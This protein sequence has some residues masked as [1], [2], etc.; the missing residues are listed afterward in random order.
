M[1]LVE[2]TRVGSSMMIS[3]LGLLILGLVVLGVIASF[4]GS[5]SS[6]T[7]TFGRILAVCGA[8][9]LAFVIA[10]FMAAPKFER[11]GSAS[12]VSVRT[13]STV[14]TGDDAPNVTIAFASGPEEAT[15]VQRTAT[16]DGEMLVLPLSN[17]V[18]VD[19]L[20]EEGVRA[21]EHLNESVSPELRQA[22]AMI[23]ISGPGSVLPGSLGPNVIPSTVRNQGLSFLKTAVAE[24]LSSGKSA[25]VVEAPLAEME[26]EEYVAPAWVENP[27]E[28]YIAVK[29]KFLPPSVPVEEALRPEIEEALNQHIAKLMS[30]RLGSHDG[31]ENLAR[32]DITDSAIKDCIIETSTYTMVM[33]DTVGQPTMR[34]TYGLIAFPES[35]DQ[36][37]VKQVRGSLQHNRVVTLC[38]TAGIL[39]LSTLF[40]SIAFRAGQSKSILRKIAT[41][42][43]IMLLIV[44]CVVMFFAMSG[45]M[46]KGETF[47][48]SWSKDRVVCVID[49]LSE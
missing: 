28:G 26:T 14:Q 1:E 15:V 48:L 2:T 12:S 10:V 23:P 13:Y 39:W 27:G 29:S 38:I 32:V 47:D 45:A 49:K 40:L 34:E 3:W 25:E 31:Y 20:G 18:L 21:I 6:K 43:M 36:K 42:P 7:G 19:L 46:L 24:L 9:F 17:Q 37:L 4:S 5:S 35:L 11:S 44:P 33:E 22:Y 30:D 8:C 41:L 16:S